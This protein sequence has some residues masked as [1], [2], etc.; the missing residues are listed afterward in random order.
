MS[1]HDVL[2][3]T[4]SGDVTVKNL[5]STKTLVV[6]APGRLA[7]GAAAATLLA[8]AELS[9]SGMYANGL[10]PA[11]D[12]RAEAALLCEEEFS[13]ETETPCP[14]NSTPHC[15]AW[16]QVNI[17]CGDGPWVDPSHPGPALKKRSRKKAVMFELMIAG[18]ALA[19]RL[20]A[21][22]PLARLRSST[23]VVLRVD[24]REG[25]YRGGLVAYA[26]S[27]RWHRGRALDLGQLAGCGLPLDVRPGP[28]RRRCVGAAHARGAQVGS[29]FL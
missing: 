5:R 2:R 19:R 23:D 29:R 12:L 26:G 1:A 25:S 6:L 17:L 13:A 21:A 8:A 24:H 27:F 15:K 28:V 10:I 22:P 16:S 7:V 11:A 4:N 20:A 9:S 14:P 18:A 3:F